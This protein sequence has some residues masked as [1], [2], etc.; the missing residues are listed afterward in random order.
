MSK[1]GCQT[2]VMGP[3]KLPS[4]DSNR[5]QPN[6]LAR[7]GRGLIDNRICGACPVTPTF[8]SRLDR[9]HAP[10]IY[11]TP[12]MTAH[13]LRRTHPTS[14]RTP[15]RRWG[16]HR[17]LAPLLEG[18][19]P[20]TLT[21]IHLRLSISLCTLSLHPL[22]IRLHQRED[23]STTPLLR[24]GKTRM[25]ASVCGGCWLLVRVAC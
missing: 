6:V 7:C 21:C 14:S 2:R 3:G 11:N 19:R 16:V 22:V 25:V 8:P 24:H 18:L 5:D 9:C 13:T 15:L 23:T 4:H 12:G 10:L 1:T 17:S 20:D